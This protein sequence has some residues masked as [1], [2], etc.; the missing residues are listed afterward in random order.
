MTSLVWGSLRLNPIM[1]LSWLMIVQLLTFREFLL[2]PGEAVVYYISP[3]ESPNPD[4]PGQP[5][6]TLENHSCNGT[7]NFSSENINI[8]IMLM[9]GNHT[10]KNCGIDIEHLE[11]CIIT[12][13]GSASESV[14]VYT[15]QDIWFDDTITIYIENLTLIGGELL[16]NTRPALMFATSIDYSQVTGADPGPPLRGV[17]KQIIAR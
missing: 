13:V 11:T 4:C 3:T 2:I 16:H 12:G 17:L 5:C 10:L 14:T 6:H 1:L 15:F 9:Q 8:T 7:M